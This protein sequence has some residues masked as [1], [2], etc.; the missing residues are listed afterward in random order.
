MLALAHGRELG[1]IGIGFDAAGRPK[2]WCDSLV[3]QGYGTP[4]GEAVR[5]IAEQLAGT[6][7]ERLTGHVADLGEDLDA[8]VAAI[9][10]ARRD[11]TCTWRQDASSAT[12][13]ALM[14]QPPTGIV[15]ASLL[16]AGWLWAKRQLVAHR[17][18]LDAIAGEL[19]KGRRLDPTVAHRLYAEHCGKRE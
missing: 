13:F 18:V 1:E 3:P 12:E 19:A 17:A 6:V 4:P 9:E 11:R 14:A 15:A 7:A 5:L 2:G 8:I 10:E 16:A